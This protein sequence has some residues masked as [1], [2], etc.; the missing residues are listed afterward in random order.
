MLLLMVYGL[1]TWL[2][3]LMADADYP[4]QS[5]LMFLLALNLGAMVGQV[6]GGLLADRN[7]SKKVLI[8]MLLLGAVSL[9]LFGFELHALLLYLFAAITGACTTGGQAVNNAYAAKFYPV[10]VKATG[11]GWALGIGRFGAIAGPALGGFLLN[12]NMPFVMNFIMF[13]IPE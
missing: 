5:S 3:Q 11:V 7:G 1:G 6:G 8:G 4:L 10:H 12:N 2:S 9:T 13:A